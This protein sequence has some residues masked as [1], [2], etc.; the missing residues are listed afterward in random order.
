M[1][2]GETRMSHG[3]ERPRGRRRARLAHLGLATAWAGLLLPGGAGA[4]GPAVAPAGPC[5]SPPVVGAT[6]P[7]DAAP[8]SRADD[9]AG[10]PVDAPGAIAAP[11]AAAPVPAGPPDA[12]LPVAGGRGAG[13]VGPGG[14]GTRASGT[15][16]LPTARG[17]VPLARATH[18]AAGPARHRFVPQQ[19]AAGPAGPAAPPPPAPVFRGPGPC[20]SPGSGCLGPI[21]PAPAPTPPP[22]RRAPPP[23]RAIGDQPPASDCGGG[24]G[25]GCR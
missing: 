23:P 5:A 24:F 7:V 19:V 2:P 17:P 9:G 20:D 6:P 16:G 15:A 4:A 3:G 10:S 21:Q 18:G 14:A 22:R 1:D 25:E 8:P 11:G 12:A 13:P